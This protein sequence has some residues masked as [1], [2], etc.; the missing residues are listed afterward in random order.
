MACHLRYAHEGARF[1][2]PE[3][4]LGIIPGYGGTQRLPR[5]I[6]KGRALE[7][8]MSGDMISAK[9]A[10][11]IGLVNDVF[12][13]WKKDDQG[14]DIVDAKGKKVFDVDSFLDWV[15]GKLQAILSKGPVAVGMSIEAV[16]R[17]L[18]VSIH[19]GQKVESDLFGLVCTT[20]DFHEG[21]GAFMEKRAPKFTGK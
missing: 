1:G 2:Q 11:E 13:A 4:N 8:I 3:V 7:L 17:G 14:K 9:R 5:L 21:T 20:E 16:N 6:G 18:E 19:E 12:P 10:Y 15:R